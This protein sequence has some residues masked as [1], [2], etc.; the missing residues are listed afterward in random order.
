[1]E[2]F[3][4]KT[5]RDIEVAYWAF[6][7][8]GMG[9]ELPTQYKRAVEKLLAQHETRIEQLKAIAALCRDDKT[10]KALW[11]KA[12]AYVWAGASCRR[13]A[14]IALTEYLQGEIYFDGPNDMIG[15]GSTKVRRYDAL[16]AEACIYLGKAYDGEYEFENALACFRR[17]FIFDA[18][19][20]GVY[21]MIAD[22]YRK[23]NNL[24][25]AI[26]TLEVAKEKTSPRDDMQFSFNEALV[27]LRA[28]KARGYIY[29]PRKPREKK[30]M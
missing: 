7:T 6:Q 4:T 3:K 2:L 10:P 21:L 27:D 22:T 28:K 20:Y 5:I 19:S 24:E 16:R 25:L 29:R 17:A 30:T 1:M 9:V 26:H 13:E 12:Y 8:F 11:I 14:I 18:T 23:M 15:L